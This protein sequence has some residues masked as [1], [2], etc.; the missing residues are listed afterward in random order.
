[1][2]VGGRRKEKGKDGAVDLSSNWK[3]CS[4]R[5]REQ[6]CGSAWE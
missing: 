4:D 1:M 2:V 6:E 5:E 3:L